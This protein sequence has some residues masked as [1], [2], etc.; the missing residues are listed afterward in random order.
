M[1][2]FDFA[3]ITI[4]LFYPSPDVA[5]TLRSVLAQK[6]KN[7]LLILVISQV[8][9]ESITA[10]TSFLRTEGIKFR[11]IANQDS[12]LYDAMNRGLDEAEGLPSFFVNSGDRLYDSGV[13]E[14]IA[15]KLIPGYI[16]AFSL[17]NTFDGIIAYLRMS[18]PAVYLKSFASLFR[19]Y[20]LF[21]DYKRLPPHPS[22][23]ST[24]L[25]NDGSRARFSIDSSF[26]ADSMLLKK[27]LLVD[28]SIAYHSEPIIVFHLGGVSSK[29]SFHRLCSFFVRR[30]YPRAAFE[31]VLMFLIVVL[32]ESR[33]YE[34][35]NLLAGNKKFRLAPFV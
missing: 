16:N 29:V 1:K 15:A 12:S 17:A 2:C 25:L 9:G 11:L 18:D 33:Y 27:Y 21:S 24:Y 20:V 28:S 13:S 22:L 35:V 5:Y 32:G 26:H 14:L 30:L 6:T 3:I 8:S 34:L 23:V 31:I 10:L 19:R 4:A 7:F